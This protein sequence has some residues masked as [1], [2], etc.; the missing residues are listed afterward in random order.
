MNDTLVSFIIPAYNASTTI[1]RCLDSI[2]NLNLK[3]SSYEVIII[4]DSST[5]KTVEIIQSYSTTHPNITLLIQPENHR[6]GAARNRGVSISHGKYIHF[7]D[8]DDELDSGIVSAITLAERLSLDICL[9]KAKRVSTDQEVIKS[10]ELPFDSDIVFGGIEFQEKYPFWCTAPWG[11][12]FRKG[13]IEKV[14]YPFAEDVVYEDSDFVNVHLY[15]ANRISYINQCSYIMH[16]NLASTT[17]T[18][19]YKHISDYALLGT[20]MLSFY[21][22]LNN[23]ESKFASFILEGG[24]YNIMNSCKNLFYLKSKQEI[25]SFYDRF[26]TYADRQSLLQYREPKY[27]W[28][29]WTRFCLAYRKLATLVVSVAIPYFQ[30]KQFITIR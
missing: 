30:A 4:D 1:V 13:F 19:S 20:R 26:D 8:S 5:D 22:S 15:N 27:C 25:R 16:E 11:Y 2:Y 24:S 12:L 7:L 18:L 28:T 23:K 10:Y 14:S 17:H 21:N 9:L 6:Q 3:G 29:N